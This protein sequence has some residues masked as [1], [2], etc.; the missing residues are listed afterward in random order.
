MLIMPCL[1]LCLLSFLDIT[2]QRGSFGELS[3]DGDN[4]KVVPGVNHVQTKL[5]S[6]NDNDFKF[7]LTTEGVDIWGFTIGKL[8][9]TGSM[10]KCNC[11]I[12]NMS[13]TISMLSFLTKPTI[14]I[15]GENLTNI[16]S[17]L[18]T[19]TG[20]VLPT[21]QDGR[22]EYRRFHFPTSPELQI[23]AIASDGDMHINQFRVSEPMH[24]L[25][26]FNMVVLTPSCYR[27]SG[28]YTIDLRSICD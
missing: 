23:I 7:N 27:I 25:R 16:D 11:E 6:T 19:K 18:I 12:Y 26:I 22:P 10:T 4:V 2:Y 28:M 20:K 21:H 1:Q 9:T 14:E 24:D 3:I 8:L 13:V 5:Q 15:W 17:W